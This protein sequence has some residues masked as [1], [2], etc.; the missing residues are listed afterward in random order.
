MDTLGLG[1]YRGLKITGLVVG[2]S[3]GCD[4]WRTLIPFMELRRRGYDALVA[5]Y[6]ERLGREPDVLVCNRLG[7][8]TEA[9]AQQFIDYSH[10]QRTIV[11]VDQDDNNLILPHHNPHW[12]GEELD[13][14]GRLALEQADLVTCTTEYLARQFREVNAHVVV[15]PNVIAPQAWR[16]PTDVGWRLDK[17]LTVGVHGGD[18]HGRDWEILP[19]LFERLAAKYERDQLAF[20]IGGDKPAWLPALQRSLGDRLHNVGWSDVEHYPYTVGQIDIALCPLEDTEFNRCKSPIKWLE[21]A[22]FQRPVVASRTLYGDYI[23][24][25][26]TGLLATDANEW[27]D[28]IRYLIDRLEARRR[29]G[30]AAFAEALRHYNVRDPQFSRARMAAYGDAWQRVVGVKHE[31]YT[32]GRGASADPVLYSVRSQR[33]ADG[34]AQGA[35]ATKRLPHY[36]ALGPWGP[37]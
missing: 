31:N 23:E 30:R 3:N 11:V 37:N 4:W 32:S 5:R 7:L 26:E 6:G 14:A 13:R 35:L 27:Y 34:G 20:F 18:S 36:V 1:P 25:G 8:R 21:S 16:L 28:R 24:D 19:A 9:Q 17:R 2:G 15:L 33:G 22:M 10:G 29:I 12:Q